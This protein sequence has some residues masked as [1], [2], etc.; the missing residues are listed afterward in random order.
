M[1]Y[2][3]HKEISIL[4]QSMEMFQFL[5]SS[6]CLEPICISFSYEK[7]IMNG[8]QQSCLVF[9]LVAIATTETQHTLFIWNTR[10]QYTNARIY[11]HS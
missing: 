2:I 9:G 11:A 5:T 7:V 3:Y 6:S 8:K 4:L 10:P 1:Y